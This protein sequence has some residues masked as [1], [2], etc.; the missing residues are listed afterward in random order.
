MVFDPV[1]V[2][3]DAK[4]VAR[5]LGGEFILGCAEF[6]VTSPWRHWGQLGSCVWTR[7]GSGLELSFGPPR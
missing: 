7:A 1:S 2:T 3:R 6:G 4:G 5:W